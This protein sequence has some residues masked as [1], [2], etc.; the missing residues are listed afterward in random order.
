MHHLLLAADRL[1]EGRDGFA[2]PCRLAMT[3]HKL[4]SRMAR[5]AALFRLGYIAVSAERGQLS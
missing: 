5:L 3:N 4:V 2:V 1:S